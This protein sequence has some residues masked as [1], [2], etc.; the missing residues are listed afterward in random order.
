M[1]RKVTLNPGGTHEKTVDISEIQ[2]PDL[3]HIAQALKSKKSAPTAVAAGDDVLEVWHLAHS[4]KK[5]IE[6]YEIGPSDTSR[7]TPHPASGK[8]VR[9][10]SK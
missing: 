3:W 9:T 8:G 5:H 6:T 4:L 2:I 7:T 1:F 10:R